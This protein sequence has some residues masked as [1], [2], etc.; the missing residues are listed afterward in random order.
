MLMLMCRAIYNIACLH[1]Q[2]N[3]FCTWFSELK[4]A[5]GMVFFESVQWGISWRNKEGFG[6]QSD[7]R[8][9]LCFQ[10][11]H[12]CFRYPYIKTAGTMQIYQV[13]KSLWTNV[14][15]PSDYFNKLSVPHKVKWKATI[16][17]SQ[18]Q[19]RKIHD[20]RYETFVHIPFCCFTLL[21]HFI[22]LSLLHNV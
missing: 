17:S 2:K 13:F 6:E 21:L 20:L 4:R 1:V 22:W 8:E 14:L 9:I 19:K 15:S 10:Y 16:S 3:F 5:A 7:T 12:C 11:F 18:P